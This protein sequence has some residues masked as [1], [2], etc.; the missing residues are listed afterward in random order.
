M[1]PRSQMV[2]VQ[3]CSSLQGGRQRTAD[4]KQGARKAS[5]SQETVAS[6]SMRRTLL[7]KPNQQMYSHSDTPVQSKRKAESWWQVAANSNGAGPDVTLSKILLGHSDFGMQSETKPTVEEGLSSSRDMLF[8][9]SPHLVGDS[10]QQI[11]QLTPVSRRVDLAHAAADALQAPVQSVELKQCIHH[12]HFPL[13]APPLACCLSSHSSHPYSSTGELVKSSSEGSLATHAKAVKSL[14]LDEREISGPASAT[15][16]LRSNADSSMYY[17]VS[18]NQNNASSD[19]TMHIHPSQSKLPGSSNGDLGMKQ[20]E[21]S[22]WSRV[23][24]IEAPL[25]GTSPSERLHSNQVAQRK[26]YPPRGGLVQPG[27]TRSSRNSK[28][29]S[30]THRLPER[31]ERKQNFACETCRKLKIRCVLSLGKSRCSRCEK[32]N[33]ECLD[34]SSQRVAAAAARARQGLR[35]RRKKSPEAEA[36]LSNSG[37]AVLKTKKIRTQTFPDVYQEVVDDSQPHVQLGSIVQVKAEGK[38]EYGLRHRRVVGVICN[39]VAVYLDGQ[40]GTPIPC[41]LIKRVDTPLPAN[42]EMEDKTDKTLKPEWTKTDVLAVLNTQAIE[43]EPGTLPQKE[44]S[45]ISAR[46]L[47]TRSP[48]LAKELRR[49]LQSSQTFEKQEYHGSSIRSYN[50]GVIPAPALQ[51]QAVPTLSEMQTLSP[52]CTNP[53]PPQSPYSGKDWLLDKPIAQSEYSNSQVAILQSCG[54]SNYRLA[55]APQR[56]EPTESIEREGGVTS[57]TELCRDDHGKHALWTDGNWPTPGELVDLCLP[58]TKG[59]SSSEN[60]LYPTY[61]IS[62]RLSCNSIFRSFSMSQVTGVRGESRQVCETNHEKAPEGL[63]SPI[64]VSESPDICQFIENIYPQHNNL[65][66]E[67]F[68]SHTTQSDTIETREYLRGDGQGFGTEE[69]PVYDDWSKTGSALTLENNQ[70]GIGMMKQSGDNVHSGH[71]DDTNTD[72]AICRFSARLGNTEHGDIIDAAQDSSI[73]ISDGDQFGCLYEC[74]R[75][76]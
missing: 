36:E 43:N 32:S 44:S 25:S 6:Q 38:N 54:T 18:A 75:S 16:D 67:D 19:N 1:T 55:S 53:H 51:H 40:E 62:S 47:D 33:S 56:R 59:S 24:S 13:H 66:G 2:M 45:Q 8:A 9:G 3:P 48:T 41:S 10:T 20:A 68:Q 4:E 74:S 73:N 58:E 42:I 7:G 61:P 12:S 35:K 71:F 30:D 22:T 39:V 60:I 31:F 17:M 46:I 15:G 65:I 69:H 37:P 23:N 34:T 28:E 70:L 21:A 52:P 26:K 14:N 50:P 27:I 5:N 11:C 76:S 63:R 49:N 57:T 72:R 64:M 29:A